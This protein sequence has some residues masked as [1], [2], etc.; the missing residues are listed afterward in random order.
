MTKLI[1]I[2]PSTDPVDDNERS[3]TYDENGAN[4]KTRTIKGGAGSLENEINKV[5]AG[6][7]IGQAFIKQSG[8]DYDADWETITATLEP[9]WSGYFSFAD[10]DSA[11]VFTD[12]TNGRPITDKTTVVSGLTLV[13]D[14]NNQFSMG[15]AI[16]SIA[17]LS[18]IQYN[19]ISYFS[20]FVKQPN[21]ITINGVAYDIWGWTNMT[22]NNVNGSWTL[23]SSN[24]FTAL[25]NTPNLSL[26]HI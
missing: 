7:T 15:I 17:G 12:A 5:P 19:N 3:F 23:F 2:T 8:D 11:A 26:I 25:P 9:D 13:R 24:I 18:D 16:P 20:N 22:L 6:G 4:L 10:F 21:Q 14:T 1:P